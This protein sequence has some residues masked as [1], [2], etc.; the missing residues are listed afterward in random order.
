MSNDIFK[1]ILPSLLENNNY[2]INSTEEESELNIYLMNK[3][4]SSHI[5]VILYVNEMNKNRHLDKKLQYDYLFYSVRKYKRKYQKWM[6]SD[7]KDDLE[8][9]KEYF[10]YSS[11]KAR[12][13]IEF[14]SKEDLQYIADKLNKGGKSK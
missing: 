11:K 8:L 1:D 4:L 7:V 14:L 2:K 12:E 6:K 10:S 3:A 13:V 9:V 5:D